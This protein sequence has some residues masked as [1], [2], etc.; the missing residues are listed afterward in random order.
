LNLQE[1]KGIYEAMTDFKTALE[2]LGRAVDRLEDAA[3]RCVDRTDDEKRH[4]SSEL[5]ILHAEYSGL[6]GVTEQVSRNLDDTIAR[7]VA[8]LEGRA[9]AA[10]AGEEGEFGP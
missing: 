1:Y 6:S 9:D 4:L 8:V 5:Q 10:H 3:Q 7:L 2:R